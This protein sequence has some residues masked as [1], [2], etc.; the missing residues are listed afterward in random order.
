MKKAFVLMETFA[1]TTIMLLS[2]LFLS[3][4]LISSCK[5]VQTAK[6]NYAM[7]KIKSETINELSSGLEINLPKDYEITN[8][9]QEYTRKI[10]ITDK[11]TISGK[12]G[13]INVVWKK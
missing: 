5:L 12:A 2:V 4:L 7:Q 6:E 11:K 9:E 3:D 10:E 8:S 1:V 13:K